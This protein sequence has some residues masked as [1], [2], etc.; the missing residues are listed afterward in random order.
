MRPVVIGAYELTDTI[1]LRS[2][3]GFDFDLDD[4]DRNEFIYQVGVDAGNQE[5]A[6]VVDILGRQ[7]LES[8]EVGES[9]IDAAFG[10]KWKP[11]ENLIFST[12]LVVPLNDDGL[13]SDLITT[14]GIE[15]R[16]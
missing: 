9:I 3:L 12:N 10:F 1:N 7:K 4:S 14:I 2:T 11:T 13:R 16:N 6:G 15:Y 5:F 8:V